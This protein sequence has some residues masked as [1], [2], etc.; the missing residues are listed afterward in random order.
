MKILTSAYFLLLIQV[1][2]SFEASLG[3]CTY[4]KNRI[5]ESGE[6]ICFSKKPVVECG[7]TCKPEGYSSKNVH[8]TC[9]SRGSKTSK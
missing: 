1:S 5:I 7:S 2:R 3:K 6:E 9:M 4:H 8:Y